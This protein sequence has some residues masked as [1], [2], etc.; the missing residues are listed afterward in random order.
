MTRRKD[1]NTRT[2]R[3]IGTHAICA[4]CFKL[5]ENLKTRKIIAKTKYSPA[6][7]TTVFL[8]YSLLSFLKY[9]A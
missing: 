7:G 1:N 2:K 9:Y 4:F 8:G 3:T 5:K 6:T